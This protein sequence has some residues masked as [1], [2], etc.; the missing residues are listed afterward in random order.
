MKI[1]IRIIILKDGVVNEE[2]L[3]ENTNGKKMVKKA[4]RNQDVRKE[5]GR[6]KRRLE[7]GVDLKEIT[8]K[9]PQAK[10][11]IYLIKGDDGRYLFEFK[12]NDAIDILGIGYRG[13]TKN[14]NQFENLM[15]QMYVKEYR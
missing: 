7:K 3:S 1:R 6:I 10:N 2:K 4:L 13:D 11:G 15:N 14:M 5:Y 8:K 9:C 12:G